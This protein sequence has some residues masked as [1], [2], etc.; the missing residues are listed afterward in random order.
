MV[1]YKILLAVPTALLLLS[2]AFLVYGWSQTGE[3]FARSIE[4][5]GGTLIRVDLSGPVNTAEIETALSQNFPAHVREIRGFAGYGLLV[6]VGPETAP[7]QVVQKL[8]DLGLSIANPSITT[9]GPSLGAAFWQQAQ[10][11]IITAFILMGIIVFAIFR[12]KI[13]SFAVMLAA[14]SDITVTLAIMQLVGLELSLAGLAAIL[15]LIGYSIDTDIMLTTRIL[16]EERGKIAERIKGAFKTGITMTGTTIGALIGLLAFSLS[17][18]L[19]QI[20]TVLLIGLIVDIIFT[21]LQNSVLLRWHCERK[22]GV[23]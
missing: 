22:E 12:E 9:F 6:E 1:N 5:K 17:P 13:P 19:S 3:W 2:M 7:E 15:M 20:A 8:K 4:L 14:L 18:V 10:I 11:A 21:W 23:C 16:R